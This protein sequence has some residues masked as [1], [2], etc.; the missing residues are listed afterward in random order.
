MKYD[1]WMEGLRLM[2]CEAKASCI[3]KDIEAESFIEAVKKVYKGQD[4]TLVIEGD[5]A[6]DWGCELFP[7]ETE[8]RRNFG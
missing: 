3:A 8:A 6:F 1:I 7:S 5:R 4:S 2:E